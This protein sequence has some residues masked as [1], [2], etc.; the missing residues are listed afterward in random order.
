[1]D[2]EAKVTASLEQLSADL[3]RAMTAHRERVKGIANFDDVL[4]VLEQAAGMLG[5]YAAKEIHTKGH[6]Y[7]PL[8]E[9]PDHMDRALSAANLAASGLHSGVC[10]MFHRLFYT[11]TEVY[12]VGLGVH[13]DGTPFDSDVDTI[14]ETDGTA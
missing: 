11:L 9:C 3:S 13:L 10:A 6:E 12:G 8:E 4:T 14:G 2:N 5:T 1:M 7:L